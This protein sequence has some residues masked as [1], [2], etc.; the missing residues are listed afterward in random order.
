[1]IFFPGDEVRATVDGE[2]VTG[3]IEAFMYD[4]AAIIAGTPRDTAVVRTT[5]PAEGLRL[6]PCADLTAAA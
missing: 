3:V 5:V 1:M 2:T 4:L 6:V